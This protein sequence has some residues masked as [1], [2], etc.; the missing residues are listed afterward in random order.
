[1]DKTVDRN[2][3]MVVHN[4]AQLLAAFHLRMKALNS[5]SVD[6]ILLSN[7]FDEEYVS[8]L[9]KF[10][11]NVHLCKPTEIKLSRIKK[12]ELFW[13]PKKILKKYHIFSPES[14]SDVY[15][16][17]PDILFYCL[18]KNQVIDRVNYNW[19]I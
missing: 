16:F 13:T 1:M 4:R 5:E 15:F 18:R 2:H 10:F 8:R 17:N 11:S 9:K 3:L 6:L 14:Y 7:Q 19:H 12:L